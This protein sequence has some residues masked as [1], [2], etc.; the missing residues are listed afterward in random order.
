M[1]QQREILEIIYKSKTKITILQEA[2]RFKNK[3]MDNK[4]KLS[5]AINQIKKNP[6]I[7]PTQILKTSGEDLIQME[8]DQQFNRQLSIKQEAKMIKAKIIRLKIK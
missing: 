4:K 3:S 8:K 5:K 6:I 1:E 2:A 7:Q